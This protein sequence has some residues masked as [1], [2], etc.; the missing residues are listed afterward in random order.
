MSKPRAAC[1]PVQAYAV[2]K[3]SYIL[4]TYPCFD[5]FEL[6]VFDAGGP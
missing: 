6:D 4:I 5:D 1:G 2:V 3:V